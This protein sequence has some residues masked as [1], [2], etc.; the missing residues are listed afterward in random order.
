MLGE[1]IIP[2]IFMAAKT[3]VEQNT[4]TCVELLVSMRDNDQ[5]NFE[6]VAASI[7]ALAINVAQLAAQ[8]RQA[9]Q[10]IDALT[11]A[12]REQN[13]VIN[14]HLLVA[15]QQSANIEALTNLA[16]ALASR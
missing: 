14:N 9:A 3:K 2:I 6:K 1:S 11:Q 8:Q 15:Q 10:N 4:E 5:K 16:T 13:Q 12:I 7:D